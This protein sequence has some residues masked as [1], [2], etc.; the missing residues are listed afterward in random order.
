MLNNAFSGV[1]GAPGCTDKISCHSMTLVGPAAMD[2]DRLLPLG[3]SIDYYLKNFI[4][5]VSRSFL[6]TAAG[7]D[8]ILFPANFFNIFSKLFKANVK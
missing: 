8:S 4:I 3:G 7:M 5:L 6:F 1:C 2:F